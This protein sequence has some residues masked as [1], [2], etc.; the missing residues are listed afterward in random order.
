MRVLVYTGVFLK[1]VRELVKVNETDYVIATDGAFDQLLKEKIKI[2]LVVGDMDSV[3]NV[4]KL[5]NFE[6]IKLNVRKDNTDTKKALEKA[7]EISSNVIL[8]GGIQGPRIEHF[9]G[10]LYLFKK[11]PKLI[12][13]DN[14]SKIYLTKPGIYRVE[15][16]RYINIFSYPKCILTLTGFEYNL[17]EYHLELYDSLIISNE[18][19][20]LYGEIEILEG[21]AI[22]IETKKD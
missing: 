10:N 6:Q 9:I 14:N 11:F 7:F 4:K 19:N 8:I 20:K 22:V 13:V 16:G 1:N 2:D 3:K 18:V 12:M 17:N 15:K 21:N 5:K